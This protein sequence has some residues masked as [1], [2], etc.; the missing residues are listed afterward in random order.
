MGQHMRA[1]I[2]LLVGVTLAGAIVFST[3]AAPRRGGTLRVA[4]IGEPLTLDTVATTATQ[5]SSLT[6]AIFEEL[7]AF[8]SDWRVPPMLAHSSTRGQDGRPHT[9]TLRKKVTLPNRK[10][11]NAGDG[12]ASPTPRG[13]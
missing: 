7:F 10:E 8:D 4:E 13:E 9:L 1:A 11:K 12:V 2:A 6:H 3:S 5:T